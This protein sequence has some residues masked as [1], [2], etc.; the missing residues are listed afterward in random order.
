MNLGIRGQSVSSMEDKE[1]IELRCCICN[2][3]ID[4]EETPLFFECYVYCDK[5]LEEMERK[6]EPGGQ[7]FNKKRG[8]IRHD[9]PETR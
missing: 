9:N 4:I 6:D 3:K 5:C 8:K 1:V 7:R 2:R